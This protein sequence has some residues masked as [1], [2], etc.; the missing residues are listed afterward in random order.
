M[1]DALYTHIFLYFSVIAKD[2]FS[3]HI[4]FAAA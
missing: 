2:M 1:K 3:W 4:H